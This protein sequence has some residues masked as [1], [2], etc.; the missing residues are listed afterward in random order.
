VRDLFRGP[1]SLTYSGERLALYLTLL[2]AFPAAAAIGFVIHEEVGMSQVALFLVIAMVY[3]TLARGRLLGTSVRI[4]ETQYPQ[5]FAI[6]KRCAAALGLPMPLVF[7]REDYHTP[8]LA[9]GFGEPYSL[10]IS[11]IW[12]EHFKEDELTFMI[13]REL[14]HIASGHTRLTS[15]LSVS[16][17][18]NVIV[19]LVFGAWL[20]KMELT[21][22]RVGL[23]CCGSL[24]AAMRA[25]AIASFGHFGR[26]I[27]HV[28]F[29]EQSREVRSDSI[30]K[31]GEWIGA[32]PYVSTRVDAMRSFMHSNLYRIHEEN[33]VER[34]A[35]E[36]PQLPQLGGTIV[37][38][39]DCAGWWRRLAAVVLDL[40]VVTAIVQILFVGSHR[41]EDTDTSPKTAQHAPAA[42]SNGVVR[43]GP[44]EFEVG[45]GGTLSFRRYQLA[46]NET[47][48]WA[49]PLWL[50]IY[51][52][53]LIALVGQT[54]GMLITGLR[55]VRTD[56]RSPSLVQ[57]AWRYLVMMFLW[58]LILVLSPF[59][60]VFLHD[61]LSYTR[62]IKTERVLARAVPA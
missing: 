18:E 14:G 34:S 58:P 16:G 60:R 44:V 36:P 62:V 3:V 37:T 40:F 26:K 9:V 10:V 32:T 2:F 47:A 1:L 7:V 28:M 13:G 52:A 15:L 22:D 24:D 29:A 30:F 48:W 5:V 49:Q 20:R 31:L 4:H 51:S 41:S 8:V 55:V 45:N 56:F 61:K 53:L 39:K 50:A 21:C 43:I 42:T 12:I 33:F 19:S 25:I 54:P 46:G 38:K 6:V 59:S 11:T 57:S 35:A 27:N 23:L 17:N